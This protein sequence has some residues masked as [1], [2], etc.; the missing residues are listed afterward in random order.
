MKTLIALKPLH[1]LLLAVL[2]FSSF[3]F[4]IDNQTAFPPKWEKLGQRKVNFKLDRDE[5][6]VTANEGA[7]SAIKIGVKN[8]GINMH[9]C[10][11]HFRNGDT[12]N[13]QLRDNIAAGST[14]RVIDLKGGKRIIKKVVFW[15]DTKNIKFKKGTLE[16]WG[17]H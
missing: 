8:T 6:F 9:R 4:T 1:L 17:R 5:I 7:F 10:V 11:V 12:Q 16:L 14:T 13:V 15:Y 2:A 3:S